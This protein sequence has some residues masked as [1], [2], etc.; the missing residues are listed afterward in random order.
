MRWQMHS[1]SLAL[2]SVKMAVELLVERR[3]ER[4]KEEEQAASLVWATQIALG[5]QQRAPVDLAASSAKGNKKRR[6]LG[7]RP[8]LSGVDPP[9]RLP[10]RLAS[11]ATD[12]TWRAA[13]CMGQAELDE[14][15][16]KQPAGEG[17]LRPP[18]A[19]ASQQNL[20]CDTRRR[21]S[22]VV[23]ARADDDVHHPVR[24]WSGESKQRHHRA[25]QGRPQCF[26]TQLALLLP[27]P[28]LRA[29][30]K[31]VWGAARGGIL[32]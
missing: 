12:D 29:L 10:Q 7:C 16:S 23:G 20:L 14:T 13:T 4:E 15:C 30:K 27:S 9:Q 32:L 3:E 31:R 19:S 18:W 8:G 24:P 1:H 25:S 2:P 5:S 28:S 11:R 17:W 6:Q 26:P 22:T 21:C